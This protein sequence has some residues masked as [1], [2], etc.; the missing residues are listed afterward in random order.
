MVTD[1]MTPQIQ[2]VPPDGAAIKAR[3]EE[4]Y[5]SQEALASRA[6]VSSATVKRIEKGTVRAH[7]AT[8]Q[9]LLRA[10]HITK[11]FVSAGEAPKSVRAEISVLRSAHELLA[12][13]RPHSTP[14]QHK[15]V[16]EVRARLAVLIAVAQ[17]S[18]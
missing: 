17:E 13:M 7:A 6:G 11:P 16:E 10:L 15:R 9:A 3:R 4:L 1:P 18:A 8:L 5:L 12:L 14:D 2:H